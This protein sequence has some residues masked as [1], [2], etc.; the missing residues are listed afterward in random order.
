LRENTGKISVT[1]PKNG[2]ATM[3][4][5]GCPKNQN[6]CCHRIAPP[7][8]GSNTWA[9]KCRSASRP[10]KAAVRTGKATRMRIAV[11]RIS[12]VNTGSRHIVMPG[13]RR[14]VM[15]VVMFTAPRMVPMPA[16]TRPM[17]HRSPPTCG[18][19]LMLLSGA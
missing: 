4:T 18:E 6:R 2:N 1:M 16:T 17:S 8:A 19:L 9:P 11:A 7:L 13:Q 12:Q 15:V 10:S 5:S 14:Q 3:Y